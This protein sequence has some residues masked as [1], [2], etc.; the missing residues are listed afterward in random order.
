[1]NNS[2][3]NPKLSLS[4]KIELEPKKFVKI[5]WMRLIS[6]GETC[7]RCGSTEKELNRAMYILKQSFAPL[8]ID[9]ILEKEE[10][11][12]REFKKDPLQSNQI[13]INDRVLEDW[14][15]GA[16]GR[17]P[18]CDVCGENDCRTVEVKGRVYETIPGEIIIKAGLLAASELVDTHKAESNCE[19]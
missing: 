14:M 17:S 11:S 6:N 12:D 7:R 4:D 19:C 18:C 9:I 16:V 5:R 10:L 13:W 15:E 3:E 2:K 1:L 8:G